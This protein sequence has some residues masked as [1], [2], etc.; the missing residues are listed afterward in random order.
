MQKRSSKWHPEKRSSPSMLWLLKSS[1]STGP[2]QG[3]SC[4]SATV[5]ECANNKEVFGTSSAHSSLSSCSNAS[6]K[7]AVS[8]AA[9]LVPMSAA[10]TGRNQQ[11]YPQG[12]NR[13]QTVQAIAQQQ[14]LVC[15]SSRLCGQHASYVITTSLS[16]AAALRSCCCVAHMLFPSNQLHLHCCT[17]RATPNRSTCTQTASAHVAIHVAPLLECM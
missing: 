2:H 13:P 1:C 8:A 9:L 17:A 5:R 7:A 4:S 15:A 10:T 12:T 3:N 11:L 6:Q 14:Q 16:T